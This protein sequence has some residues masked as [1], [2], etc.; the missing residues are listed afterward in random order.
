MI[1]ASILATVM[2]PYFTHKLLQQKM[3]VTNEHSSLY[4]F[5]TDPYELG[6]V[7]ANFT[8]W[9]M[10]NVD[11]YLQHGAPPKMSA[12]GPFPHRAFQ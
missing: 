5:L 6:D 8:V 10:T 11:D 7:F 1:A 9:N 12:V 4:D 3:P 2:T